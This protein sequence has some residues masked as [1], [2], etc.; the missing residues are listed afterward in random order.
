MAMTQACKPRE[1]WDG[2]DHAIA[3]WHEDQRHTDV[4]GIRLRARRVA[5]SLMSDAAR[6]RHADHR[7]TAYRSR[8]CGPYIGLVFVK[9]GYGLVHQDTHSFVVREGDVWIVRDCEP[10]SL[11]VNE[12]CRTFVLLVPEERWERILRSPIPKNGAKFS[13]DTPLGAMVANFMASLSDNMDRLDDKAAEA[14]IEMALH[15]A[16]T[17]INAI[18]TTAIHARCGHLLY[19]RILAYIDRQL[20]SMELS[21]E[22]IARTHDISLRY[23]QMLFADNGWTVARWIRERRLLHCREELIHFADRKSLT[24]IAYAWGFSDS[25][26]FSRSFR[27]RFGVPPKIWREQ[28]RAANSG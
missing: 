26:H 10:V 7:Y 14:A 20:D 27:K 2:F 5:D 11:T 28:F 12:W 19:D 22:S 4:A 9:E 15:I 6:G 18:D 17:A 1:M 8:G 25:A 21:P 24:E 3:R 16:G 23:L 13:G